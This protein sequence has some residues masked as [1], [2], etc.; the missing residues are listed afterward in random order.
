MSEIARGDVFP[1]LPLRDIVVFPHMIVPLFVGRDK[2]VRALEDVMREDKQILLVAQKNAAQDDPTTADIYDVGTV[3]TVLQLLKLPDGTVKVLVEGGRRARITGFTDNE[4]FFQATAEMIDDGVLEGQELEALSRSVVGQFEQYIKLNKKIPPEVLVSV[5]QIEDPAKLA[6]TVASHLSLKISEKQ[7]L[8]ELGTTAERL[9]RVYSYMEG[10][11]GVLQVEKKIRNRVK[12]QMEKT[13]REYYLNEQLKAIQKELGE[14]DDG[15]DES[16]ELEERIAKTRLSKEAREKALAE[17]KKLKSMSPMSAEATVVRNYLDWILTIPWKK[18]TKVKKDVKLAEK[19]LNSEHYGLEKVKERIVEYLAVQTRTEKVKGPILCLV[20]PPGVGKTSLGKSMAQA[21]GR[22]FVR[23]S[24]GGVRDEAEV[25]G[26]RRTYIGSMPGK[27]IQGMKKAKSSNP[28]FLLDE[29]DKLGADW[30]GDPSSALLE[31]LDPEQNATFNDHYL[32]VDYDLSDVMFVTTAN[33]LRMPQPLLDRMELIRLSGYTED[34]KVEIAKRHLFD[35]VATAA[36]L[37]K[38]EWT[39]SDDAIRDLCRYYTR[40]AG[41][42]SLERELANLA[43]KATT[44][45]VSKGKLKVAVTPRNL[46]KY[47][48]VR[49][50]RFGEAELEDM[51][52]AVTGLAW[53]EVGG[54][55]L[56]IEAVTMPGKGSFSHTGKLGDVM[57]ESVQAARSYVRSRS[58][59]LGIKPTVFEK[60]DIHVHVPEGATP[61]DGPS[62]GIAMCTAIVSAITGITVRR[63]VAMT[64]EI[65]L[66]GR[67]LPIGGLKEKLLAALRGGLKTVLIPKDNEKDLAEIPDNVKK[68]LEI[69]PVGT[70]DEV[71]ARALTRMPVPIEWEEPADGAAS[72]T[73]DGEAGAVLTH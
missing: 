67:V 3:S 45:I 18:R 26:H 27:I 60:K 64:G 58:V 15:K 30:R 36:G 49:K 22:N 43:R 17:L 38:G 57:Q 68:G 40:E 44:E 33:T 35:K 59:S 7:E 14:G 63:E 6:D 20:G 21:T 70:V 31:V 25:R 47:A 11:I 2:S 66:R 5:N 72:T 19:I 62:A 28:L 53:T 32:E 41:V 42:R 29:I 8:L 56:T 54:E 55:L 51:V 46:E 61:K 13:Q 10:E 1:V 71:L 4:S 52:G 73:K 16:A 9:E 12:R 34:E 65:T 39:V 37:K 50:Y 23:I 48:G 69:V 24:L